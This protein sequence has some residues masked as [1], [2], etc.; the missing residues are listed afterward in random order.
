M[1]TAWRGVPDPLHGDA[2]NKAVRDTAQECINAIFDTNTQVDHNPFYEQIDRPVCGANLQCVPPNET[3]AA[4][5]RANHDRNTG[6]WRRPAASALFRTRRAT[7][8]RAPI[9]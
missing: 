4:R 3:E 1:R 7:T 6:T 2:L 5:F 8:R 9:H